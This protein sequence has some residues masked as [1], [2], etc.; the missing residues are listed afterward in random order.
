MGNRDGLKFGKHRSSAENFHRMFGSATCDC[1]AELRQK[2][3]C[4]LWLCIAAFC[5]RCWR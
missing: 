2:I 3:W 5:A 1:S 4:H